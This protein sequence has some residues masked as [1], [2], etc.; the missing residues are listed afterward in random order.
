M[1]NT[2]ER[3]FIAVVGAVSIIFVYGM[4][5]MAWA[6]DC[7]EYGPPANKVVA[8][9]PMVFSNSLSMWKALDSKIYTTW[10]ECMAV[11]PHDGH[12]T[13]CVVVTWWWPSNN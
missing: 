8:Y 13:D 11:L 9:T 3:L 2:L 5:S 4:L 12:D 1:I 10:E 7:D 6:A